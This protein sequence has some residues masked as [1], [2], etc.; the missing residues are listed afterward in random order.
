MLILA[1][2]LSFFFISRQTQSRD[3]ESSELN[4]I[5]LTFDGGNTWN[6]TNF[7]RGLVV[8]FELSFLKF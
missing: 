2:D 7:P 5:M 3:S 1:V 8:G 4:G 6:M